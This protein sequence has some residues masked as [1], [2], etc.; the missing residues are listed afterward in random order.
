MFAVSVKSLCRDSEKMQV[1]TLTL[2]RP[3]RV[4]ASLKF[5]FTLRPS[6][7]RLLPLPLLT[8]STPLRLPVETLRLLLTGSVV[9]VHHCKPSAVTP[10][11][12]PWNYCLHGDWPTASWLLVGP[13]HVTHCLLL[14]FLNSVL[15][16][17][18]TI[19]DFDSDP[20]KNWSA[21]VDGAIFSPI[22]L[23]VIDSKQFC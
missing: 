5:C 10:S 2:R 19:M 21:A 3:D 1:D 23:A 11:S 7:G 15:S 6:R 13:S 18:S 16:C 20:H 17:S 12:V 4:A 9:G 14:C 8:T 22:V